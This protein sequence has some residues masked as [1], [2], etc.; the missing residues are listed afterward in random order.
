LTARIH[1]VTQA[2]NSILEL[3]SKRGLVGATLSK[4]STAATTFN[5]EKH[6]GFS[7]IASY[8]GGSNN[9]Q[10][11][12]RPSDKGFRLTDCKII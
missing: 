9:P 6:R 12:I 2:W 10:K 8:V 1:N 3:Q 5:K 11:G 7:W 4:G